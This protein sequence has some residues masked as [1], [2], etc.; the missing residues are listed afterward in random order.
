MRS[1]ETHDR[2]M[3]PGTLDELAEVNRFPLGIAYRELLVKVFTKGLDE[4][5]CELRQRI[6]GQVSGR[7]DVQFMKQTPF[8]GLGINLWISLD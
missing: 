6:A 5:G 7:G 4:T 3:C 2:R 1:E 8:V